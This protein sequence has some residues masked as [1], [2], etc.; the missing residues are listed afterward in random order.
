MTPTGGGAKDNPL[1]VSYP[2]PMLFLQYPLFATNV[3]VLC[4]KDDG[5]MR[6]Q[7]SLA[8]TFLSLRLVYRTEGLPG[9]YRGAPLYLLHQLARDGLRLLAGRCLGR[10]E[11][12]G[13]HRLRLAARYAIDVLCYPLLLASTRAIILRDDTES[14]WQRVCCWCAEEGVL[15]LFSGLTSSLLSTALDEIMDLVLEGCVERCA[16]GTEVSATD[17]LMLKACSTSVA[18]VLTAPANSVGVV[19]RCQSPLP[20]LVPPAPLWRTLRSLPWLSTFYQFLMFGGILGLNVKL[21]QL[22]LEMEEEPDEE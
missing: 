6:K 12:A 4:E 11:G 16:T 10:R 20:G 7:S 9:L 22:K 17:K 15:S 2:S 5:R 14:T 13:G 8:G 18:S 19:Q 3:K 21:I 1:L